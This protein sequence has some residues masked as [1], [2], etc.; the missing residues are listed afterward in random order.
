MARTA[1]IFSQNVLDF[2]QVFLHFSIALTRINMNKNILTISRDLRRADLRRLLRQEPEKAAN[3]LDSMVAENEYGS[4]LLER[5]RFGP[6]EI[7]TAW[8]PGQGMV[9]IRLWPADGPCER[10]APA[11]RMTVPHPALVALTGWGPRWERRP[12]IDG[13]VLGTGLLTRHQYAMIE[14]AI[15]A[16]HETGQSHGDLTPANIIITADGAVRLIDNGER[17]KG[18]PGWHPPESHTPQQRDLFALTLLRGRIESEN[19]DI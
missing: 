2:E 6:P 15:S 7:W 13:T 16:L 8:Q 9:V 1:L 17:C 14:A 5:L 11:L 19:G 10:I 4:V 12:W 3:I 18:T